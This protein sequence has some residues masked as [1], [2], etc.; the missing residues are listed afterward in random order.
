[1]IEPRVGQV[2]ADNDPRHKGRQIEIVG[3][4]DADATHPEPYVKV[5]VVKVG[6]NVRKKEV[7]EQRTI[8]QRR[9]RP[10]RN[11]YK[12]VEDSTVPSSLLDQ[13]EDNR[14]HPERRVPRTEYPREE[15]DR[16]Y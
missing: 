11:G 16:A 6:R 2:Y 1:M 4:H 9:L 15:Q 13:I 14:A 8:L 5:R 12:L 3:V 10:T 7:G